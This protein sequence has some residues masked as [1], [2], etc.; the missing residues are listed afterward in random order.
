MLIYLFFRTILFELYAGDFPF[1]QLTPEAIVW[2]IGTGRR[3]DL[4]RVRCNVAM[5]SLIEDCWSPDPTYRPSFT[6]VLK[7]LQHTVKKF[8][9]YNFA[10]F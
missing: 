8:I 2:T 7:E 10:I 1:A 9:S 4:E 3:Q 6:G 5:K